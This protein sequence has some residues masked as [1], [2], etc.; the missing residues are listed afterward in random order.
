VSSEIDR[1][2]AEKVLGYQTRIEQGTHYPT[3]EHFDVLW[4]ETRPGCGDYAWTPHFEPSADI[5]AVFAEVIPAMREKGWGISI[6][7]LE[8][9]DKWSAEFDDL[10]YTWCK[11]QS[12]SP[13]EAIC[14]AALRAVGVEVPA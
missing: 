5:G 9:G 14:L 13:A 6:F 8:Q 1:L 11:E 2:V 10:A 7:Q 12:D 4:V 3:G